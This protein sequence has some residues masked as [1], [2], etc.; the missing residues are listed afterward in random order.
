MNGGMFFWVQSGPKILL[1]LITFSP[2]SINCKPIASI[3]HFLPENLA[4]AELVE[5]VVVGTSKVVK[6]TNRLK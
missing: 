3:D 2:Q 1:T 4:S 6:V 5:E